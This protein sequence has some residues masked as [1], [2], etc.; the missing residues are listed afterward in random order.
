MFWESEHY[1]DI[2]FAER[3]E[4][5]PQDVNWNVTGLDKVHTI[6]KE[7]LVRDYP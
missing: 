5:L 4:G 6:L 7:V 3:F 1:A 2:V